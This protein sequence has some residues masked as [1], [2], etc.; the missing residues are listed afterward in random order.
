[1]VQR[2]TF[3]RHVP[4]AT[5][6]NKHRKIKTPGGRLVYQLIKK[7][8]KRATCGDTKK[9]LNGVK[10]AT[11]KTL[12]GKKLK[13]RERKVARAY[14]GCLTAGAVRTRI[15]RAFLVEEQRCVKQ[16]LQEKEAAAAEPSQRE[17]KD[18]SKSGKKSKK[19]TKKN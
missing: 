7:T 14:G 11:R 9:A 16:V 2:Q 1:M 10:V 17:V 19:S 3:R 15:V 13:Q 4:W 18:S 5:K 8:T 12:K 6:S